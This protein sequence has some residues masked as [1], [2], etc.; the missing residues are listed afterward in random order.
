MNG[1]PRRDCSLDARDVTVR[2][3]TEDV[4]DISLSNGLSANSPSNDGV[5][6]ER[7]SEFT[8]GEFNRE[9]IATRRPSLVSKGGAGQNGRAREQ[10]GQA[11]RHRPF[12]GRSNGG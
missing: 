5:R 6:D 2:D 9:V 10:A 1:I 12:P 11:G 8:I 3:V 7:E 4:F